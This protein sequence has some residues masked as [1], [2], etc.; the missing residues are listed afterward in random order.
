MNIT[1]STGNLVIYDF[2]REYHT[3]E[4][5]LRQ[6]HSSLKHKGTL[7]NISVTLDHDHVL[8]SYGANLIIGYYQCCFEGTY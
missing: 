1:T 7:L 4:T 2:V 3:C 8:I 6:I 5:G